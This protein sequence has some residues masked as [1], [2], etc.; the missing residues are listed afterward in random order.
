MDF[1]DMND[2]HWEPFSNYY[3]VMGEISMSPKK[4]Y[5]SID[6]LRMNYGFCGYKAHT[7][8]QIAKKYNLSWERVRQLREEVIRCIWEYLLKYEDY[9]IWYRYLGDGWERIA[10]SGRFYDYYGLHK[11][12]RTG[13]Y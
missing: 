3:H 6:I 7:L 11:L 13:N 12:Y 8:R 4:L 9:D 2:T 1:S 5:R 10:E